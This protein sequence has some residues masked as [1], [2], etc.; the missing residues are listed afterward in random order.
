MVFGN[1]HKEVKNSVCDIVDPTS[2]YYEFSREKHL[3]TM[4]K[5]CKKPALYVKPIVLDFWTVP[6]HM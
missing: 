6:E 2:K 1:E 4:T 5:I 3:A